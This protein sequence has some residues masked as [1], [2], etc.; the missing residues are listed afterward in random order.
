MY[1]WTFKNGG[2]VLHVAFIISL[3]THSLSLSLPSNQIAKFTVNVFHTHF[4]GSINV[5]N[6]LVPWYESI[7]SVYLVNMKYSH[8]S[9]AFGPQLC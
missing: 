6:S 2:N 7:V 1:T 4:L 8:Y 3:P 5:S 9:Q